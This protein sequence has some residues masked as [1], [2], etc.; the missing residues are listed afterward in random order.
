MYLYS[1]IDS[2]TPTSIHSKC[3]DSEVFELNVFIF[4]PPAPW[5]RASKIIVDMCTNSR[6]HCHFKKNIYF[7]CSFG[8][9]PFLSFENFQNSISVLSALTPPA[10]F[11]WL[12]L[13]SISFSAL[14]LCK[15]EGHRKITIIIE[16]PVAGLQCS[17]PVLLPL[18]TSS[19]PSSR[20]DISRLSLSFL[21]SVRHSS[22]MF[23]FLFCVSRW[24]E[25]YKAVVTRF[26]LIVVDVHMANVLSLLTPVHFLSVF[27]RTYTAILHTC[28]IHGTHVTA[29]LMEAQT[30]ALWLQPKCSSE[31]KNSGI[32]FVICRNE[33]FRV[34]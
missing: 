13:C 29:G 3:F 1:L 10:V 31:R 4:F 6:V 17:S 28:T 19:S 15:A 25:S 18:L 2:L 23:G 22:T 20:M 33:A 16:D 9:L 27:H 14:C 11:P 21:P 24:I 8:N 7:F 12:S 26:Q 5:F 30:F 34:L 32:S